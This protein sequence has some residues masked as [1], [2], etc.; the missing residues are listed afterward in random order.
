[1][2][3]TKIVIADDI[4]GVAVA[5]ASAACARDN[6]APERNFELQA[7]KSYI[8]EATEAQISKELWQATEHRT[9]SFIEKEF[10]M[11]KQVAKLHMSSSK[12][13]PEGRLLLQKHLEYESDERR[14]MDAEFALVLEHEDLFAEARRPEPS[15]YEQTTS[16]YAANTQHTDGSHS[17][18][19]DFAA[20]LPASAWLDMDTAKLHS[21]HQIVYDEKLDGERKAAAAARVPGDRRTGLAVSS[22]SNTTPHP[23]TTLG[24][25]THYFVGQITTECLGSM[26]CNKLWQ[27]EH[28]VGFF[29]LRTSLRQNKVFDSNRKN[30]SAQLL[31]CIACVFFSLSD[32]WEDSACTICVLVEKYQNSLP[33]L[34]RLLKDNRVFV[35][36]NTSMPPRSER[37][38]EERGAQYTAVMPKRQSKFDDD[39]KAQ[40]AKFA[41]EMQAREDDRKVQQAK[42][43]AEMQAREDDRKVQQAKLAAEMQAREDD[44]KAQQQKFDDERQVR[45]QRFDE[46]RKKHRE[47]SAYSTIILR[48][49]LC[50]VVLLLLKELFVNNT[51][52]Y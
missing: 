16:K 52:N 22:A 32:P 14:R 35:N 20:K 13:D 49:I 24:D 7:G 18:E 47:L 50:I 5:G 27:L 33:L 25:A 51:R 30:M 21:L 44:R 11:R 17:T 2:E 15:D 1:M 12:L 23:S 29:I 26:I 41:A 38:C 9:G 42:F 40:Q 19:A 39:R 31:N 46:D 4:A 43:A 48:I 6:N 8:V 36:S 37:S 45:Q 34:Y 3:G 28:N 10:S